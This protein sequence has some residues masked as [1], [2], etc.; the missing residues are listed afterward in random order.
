[1]AASQNDH[2]AC[3]AMTEESLRIG[4]KERDVEVVACSLIEG[5]A[6]RWIIGDIDDAADR[7]AS[8]LTHTRVMCLE[9][10]ELNAVTALCGISVARGEL[11]RAI[12]V[13]QQGLAIS[14]DRGEL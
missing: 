13:G 14:K 6:P 1:M 11:D 7:F 5:A 8:A 4:T 10:A 3:A 2:D 9:Q 12:D